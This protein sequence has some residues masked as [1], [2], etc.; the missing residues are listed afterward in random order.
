MIPV[1]RR[2]IFDACRRKDGQWR[3]Y[4]LENNGTKTDICGAVSEGVAREECLILI[5]LYQMV[6]P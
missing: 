4:R 2:T 3:V 5:A 6:T 1:K